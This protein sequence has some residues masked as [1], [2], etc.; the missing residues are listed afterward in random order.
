MYTYVCHQSGCRDT[1][2]VFPWCPWNWQ[3]WEVWFCADESSSAAAPRVPGPGVHQS[4]WLYWLPHPMVYGHSVGGTRL[5]LR[6][7]K[8]MQFYQFGVL[9]DKFRWEWKGSA[10]LKSVFTPG[11]HLAAG[12]LG[13]YDHPLKETKGGGIC[14]TS[15][16][17]PC[18]YFSCPC[19]LASAVFP[20]HTKSQVGVN[21]A[22]FLV[23]C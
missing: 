11:S 23:W 18:F 9:E 1:K 3:G 5:S 6:M 20:L 4:Q 13:K 14:F 22:I 19:F 10:S 16:P 2:T 7:S 17:P 21:K 8:T 15:N 12:L